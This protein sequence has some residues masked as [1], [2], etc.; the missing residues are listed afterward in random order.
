MNRNYDYPYEYEENDN[1]SSNYYFNSH[2]QFFCSSDLAFDRNNLNKSPYKRSRLIQIY[3]P[4]N[5]SD[6]RNTPK[7]KL[8]DCFSKVS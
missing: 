3:P 2:P 7:S 5:V 1:Y 4:E 6:C 8:N